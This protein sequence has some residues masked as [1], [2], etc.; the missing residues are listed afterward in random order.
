MNFPSL[1]YICLDGVVCGGECT[2]ELNQQVEPLADKLPPRLQ[3]LSTV[4]LNASS[5]ILDIAFRGLVE[6]RSA[7]PKLSR[8][9]IGHGDSMQRDGGIKELGKVWDIWGNKMQD[10][11]I[12]FE[13][14][15]DNS[16]SCCNTLAVDVICFDSQ[17]NGC[18]Y[19]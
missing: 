13:I 17:W 3:E 7:F 10:A 1:E 11:G 14:R 6:T 18:S 8:I 4:M 12:K 16:Q 5:S 15:C 9:R 19:G 2:P